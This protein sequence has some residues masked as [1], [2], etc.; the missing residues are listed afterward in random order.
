MKSKWERLVAVPGVPP[1]GPIDQVK[2]GAADVDDALGG[3][4]D[5]PTGDGSAVTATVAIDAASAP[6]TN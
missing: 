3:G 1:T 5:A 2:L 4:D 6:M